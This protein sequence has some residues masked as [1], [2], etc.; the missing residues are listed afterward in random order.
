M[1]RVVFTS[2]SIE[3]LELNGQ[4]WTDRS[5]SQPISLLPFSCA[6]PHSNFRTQSMVMGDNR[7]YRG[8]GEGSGGGHRGGYG[9]KRKREDDDD[10][11]KALLTSLIQLTDKR[12]VRLEFL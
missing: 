8:N 1:E 5:R 9:H 10:G 11:T 2:D 7:R 3:W 12:P 4:M 6:Q